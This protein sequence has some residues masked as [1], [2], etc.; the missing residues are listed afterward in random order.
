M[1]M[2]AIDAKDL[3]LLNSN[4]NGISSKKKEKK[5]CIVW[6]W[7]WIGIMCLPYWMD[8]ICLACVCW[9]TANTVIDIHFFKNT[10]AYCSKTSRRNKNVNHIFFYNK[11]SFYLF[12]F[13]LFGWF[14]RPSA[15]FVIYKSVHTLIKRYDLINFD[16]ISWISNSKNLSGKYS[17]SNF[18]DLQWIKIKCKY[19]RQDFFLFTS[20]CYLNWNAYFLQKWVNCVW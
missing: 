9:T 11:F 18:L 3:F 10:F 13:Y 15:T 2:Y 5:I 17:R 14:I 1:G 16:I 4:F 6:N 20:T 19:C 7:C 8:T 12:L